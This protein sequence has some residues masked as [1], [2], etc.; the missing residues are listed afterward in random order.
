MKADMIVSRLDPRGNILD[1]LVLRGIHH[2]VDPLIL[3]CGVERLRPGTHPVTPPC[4]PPRAGFRRP[5]G[6]PGT[7]E[8]CTDFPCRSGKIVT[9]FSIG[10]LRTAMSMASHTRQVHTWLGH[11]IP[12]HLL[13]AAAWNDDRVDESRPRTDTGDITA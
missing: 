7:S 6:G 8:T 4:A 11:R 12:H 1:R 5:S 2:P 13:R 3:Q 9:P 10:H